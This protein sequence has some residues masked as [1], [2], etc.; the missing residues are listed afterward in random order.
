MSTRT[1]LAAP[2][3]AF[4]VLLVVLV[5]VAGTAH[6]AEPPFPLPPGI[7]TA[8]MPD[9]PA[10][11]QGPT[12]VI[13]PGSGGDE[14]GDPVQGPVRDPATRSPRKAGPT[15]GAPKPTKAAVRP[16]A[17]SPASAGA[18]QRGDDDTWWAVGAGVLLLGVLSEFLRIRFRT[19]PQP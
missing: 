18:P 7:P 10:P 14:L 12:Y 3:A 11:S 5:L 19:R 15:T 4:V 9:A 8:G 17:A 1:A 16:P 13:T 6:A 2:V